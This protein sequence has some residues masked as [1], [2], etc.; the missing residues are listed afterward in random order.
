M[1]GKVSMFVFIIVLGTILTT[2]LVGVDS[3]T[4]P[5]IER[6]IELKRK[7]SILQAFEIPHTPET[8]EQE[9]ADNIR[10][11]GTGAE[12][13]YL[14]SDGTIAFVFEGSGLWGP[15]EGVLAMDSEMQAIQRLVIMH[16]EETPGLGSRIAEDEFLDRFETKIFG[17]GLTLVPEGKSSSTNEIDGITGAT[18]SSEA[19]IGILNE[20]YAQFSRIVAGE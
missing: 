16:Q 18:M 20:D 6:N 9:F 2:A 5:I 8:I 11:R 1:K 14:S 17:T 15:I 4:K 10:G 12:K 19:L 7:T 3:Y 13:Y